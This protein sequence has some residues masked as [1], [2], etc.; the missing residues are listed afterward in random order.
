MTDDLRRK[1]SKSIQGPAEDVLIRARFLRDDGQGY[2]AISFVRERVDFLVDLGEGSSGIVLK[3]GAK[4]A[5]RMDYDA[6]EK[7]V[8]FADPHSTPVLDLTSVTGAAAVHQVPEVSKSFNPAAQEPAAEKRSFDDVP[9]RIALFAR[10]P[11]Q[12]NFQM[13]FFDE[14]DIDWKTVEGATDGRNGPYTKFKL[15]YGSSPFGGKEVMFDM[16]RPK[17]MEL[18]NLAK[19]KGEE[20]LD[21]RDWTRRRDPD[22]TPPPPKS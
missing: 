19:M 13:C 3:S 18:Y 5:V 20:E 9:L 14:E 8:Y 16:P 10:Q 22:K 2:A 21:L 7:A 17:F 11:Q 1:F 15:T 6:L 12:Q 4:I